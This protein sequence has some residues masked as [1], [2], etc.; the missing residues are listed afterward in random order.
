MISQLTGPVN[1]SSVSSPVVI[2]GS[3]VPF[4]E[5]AI[6]L[7]TRLFHP[8]QEP[9]KPETDKI[10]YISTLTFVPVTFDPRPAVSGHLGQLSQFLLFL[11]LLLL[12]HLLLYLSSHLHCLSGLEGKN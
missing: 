12:C 9:S 2:Y 5:L 10:I 11:L 7:E 6:A 8:C 1:S 3:H 4:L